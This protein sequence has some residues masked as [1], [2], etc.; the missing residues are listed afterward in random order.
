MAIDPDDPKVAAQLCARLRGVCAEGG[1]PVPMVAW[2]FQYLTCELSVLAK[3][4]LRDVLKQ[5]RLMHAEVRSNMKS[6]GVEVEG[7]EEDVS[8]APN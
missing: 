8:D 7:P 4:P 3:V 6:D 5:F 2:A 1:Y